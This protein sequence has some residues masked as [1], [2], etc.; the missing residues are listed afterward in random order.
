MNAVPPIVPDSEYRGL[1]GL[2]PRGWR[3][4]ALL[5]RFDRPI[6]WWLLFLPCGWGALLSGLPDGGGWRIAAMLIG[7]IAMRGAGCVYNDIVDRDLDAQVERTRSRPLPSGA[8]SVRAAWTWLAV[9]LAI[10]FG[11]WLA[12]PMAAKLWSLATLPVVVMYPFMKR[13]TWW[14]QAFLGIVFGSGALIGFVAGDPDGVFAGRAVAKWLLYAGTILWVIGYDTIYAI[15]DIEDDALVG[16]RSSARRMGRHV[17]GGVGLFYLGALA[18]WAGAFWVVRP[19]PLAL[20][21]LLPAAVHLA[22]QVA[23]MRAGDG[24]GALRR[25]RANR[26][27]GLLMLAAS[28]VVGMSGL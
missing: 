12:L 10:G 24:A 11:V 18:L 25:F 16:V 19:D 17:R 20:L 1:V 28:L 23:T 7:A 6:G 15:Q 22:W 3:P 5:A 27:T 26:D 4:Y 13:I 21:A 9:L 8:V 14:P 2:L